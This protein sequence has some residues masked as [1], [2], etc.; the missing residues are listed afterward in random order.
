MGFENG[1]LVRV[2]VRALAAPKFE[3]VN[4]FHYDLIDAELQASND[5]QALADRFRDDVLPQF[6][7]LYTSAW[8]IQP[9]VVMEEKDPLNPL[10]SRK[11]W[12]SGTPIAGTR[13][14]AGEVLAFGMCAVATLLTDHIGRRHRGRIFI[15]GS[16]DESDVTTND[17][18]TDVGHWSQVQAYLGSVPLQ[19]D[20]ATGTSSSVAHW[21]VYSR[22]QRKEN[23]PDYASKV[24]STPLHSRVHWLRS[25]M[26]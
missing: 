19:P 14:P 23:G 15:G 25:R 17:W 7:A 18:R 22:T 24:V 26:D 1:R 5:P 16:P 21:C 11:E 4:T 8:Q 2:T 6:R 10:L 13:T 20:L 3:Q 12:V 9:V